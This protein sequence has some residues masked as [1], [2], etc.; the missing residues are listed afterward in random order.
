VTPELT[1][2]VYCVVSEQPER[3]FWGSQAAKRG[4]VG[5]ARDLLQR[6]A[7]VDFADCVGRTPLMA[8]SEEGHSHVV[9]LLLSF[10][11]SVDLQDR[12][13][14]TALH[15]AVRSKCL[16]ATSISSVALQA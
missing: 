12:S 5:V 9:R 15:F 10:G 1:C 11:A 3:L 4:N 6:E 2:W 16:R 14:S 7:N 13:G 8:A